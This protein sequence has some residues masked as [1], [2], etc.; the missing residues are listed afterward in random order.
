MMSGSSIL[1]D[2]HAMIEEY[3][4]DLDQLDEGDR[5]GVMRNS[6]GVL[7]FFVNGVDQG[8][9]ATGLPPSVYAVVDMY[10]KCAQV[11]IVDQDSNRDMAAQGKAGNHCYW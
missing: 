5:I 11:T 4:R 2:G 6:A 10:G 1:K 3:G 9:A 7:R 8:P